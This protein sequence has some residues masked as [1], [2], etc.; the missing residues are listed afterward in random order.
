MS[1]NNV[2]QIIIRTGGV[3]ILWVDY[4]VYDALTPLRKELTEFETKTD[5]KTK[6]TTREIKAEYFIDDFEH[7]ELR[8]HTEYIYLVMEA[9]MLHPNYRSFKVITE[10]PQL[11]AV[12]NIVSNGLRSPRGR[13][14]EYIDFISDRTKHI[15]VLPAFMGVGKTAC[16]LFSWTQI[17]RKVCLVLAPALMDNW[18]R[19]AKDFLTIDPENPDD[20][21]CVSGGPALKKYMANLEAGHNPWKL[22]IFSL[23][24]LQSFISNY[25]E[26]DYT[27][28]P[29]ELFAKG[30]F[31]V[32]CVDEAHRC[33]HFHM[34]LDMY[35]NIATHQF[36]TATLMKED[37]FL[38]DLENTLFNMDNRCDVDP[39]TNHVTLKSYGYRF[40]KKAPPHLGA[41]GYQH[42][43]LET[44]IFKRKTLLKQYMLLLARIFYQDFV[45]TRKDGDR[46]LV[47]FATVNMVS[48]FTKFIKLKI[49]DLVV[50]KYLAGDSEEK[51]EGADIIV[52]TTKKAGTGTDIPD[53]TYVL[54]TIPISSIGENYQNVGRLRYIDDRKTTFS[55]IW[56]PS[57]SKHLEYHRKRQRDLKPLI[58]ETKNIMLNFEV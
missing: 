28:T 24:T 8:F 57:I 51:F 41:M 49:P 2:N 23:N 33:M 6:R 7:K 16:S 43:K 56:S 48:I 58:C 40:L 18:K 10:E 50:V 11:G 38:S 21:L 29:D 15:R 17:K 12:A 55:Y 26:K 32:K 9:L 34:L 25:R 42:S 39:P 3:T 35:S 5:W 13:Q 22:V 44:Q 52:S 30:E 45:T 37:K 27:Y 36:L 14:E 20:V 47:Y 4:S 46:A 54:Q 19:A 31:G 53:L 1:D